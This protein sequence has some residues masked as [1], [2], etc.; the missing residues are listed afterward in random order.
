MGRSKV[1]STEETP[2]KVITTESSFK[3][4][5]PN[6]IGS[7]IGEYVK[8]EKRDKEIVLYFAKKI[9]K[10]MDIKGGPIV[11]SFD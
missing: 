7:D 8:M 10:A 11:V 1:L 6:V 9:D 2:V 3:I 5:I 4:V